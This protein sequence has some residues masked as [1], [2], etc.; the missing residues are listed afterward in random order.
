MTGGPAAGPARFRPEDLKVPPTVPGMT[1]GLFGG[2]FD[3]PHAGHVHVAETALERLGLDRLWMMVTPGNPLK[4]R[5]GLPPLAARIDAARVL[6][7]NPRIVVTG[8]E[9]AFGSA[10][11]WA[12]VER[13]VATLPHVRFVWVMGADNLGSFH[14]WQHWRRI[15][16]AVPIAVVDRPGSTLAALS[17][18]AAA[19]LRTRRLPEHEARRLA[20]GRPP[21]WTFL[22]A[23]RSTL[24]ST[25]LRRNAGRA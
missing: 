16:D 21:I 15:A 14:R 18:P 9:E 25:D 3:P 19:A 6:I 13:L 17:S 12:T 2:S 4:R 7:R 5:P 8:F 23:P 24:S 1:V 11:S 20:H 22:H 10:Y